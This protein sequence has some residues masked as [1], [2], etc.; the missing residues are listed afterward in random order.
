MKQELQNT[1]GYTSNRIYRF[2]IIVGMIAISFPYIYITH[3]LPGVKDSLT[4]R[5]IILLIFSFFGI[6]SYYNNIIIKHLPHLARISAFIF[7]LFHLW[8]NYHNRFSPENHYPLILTFAFMAWLLS[9]RIQAV[10]FYL[11]AL[12][13]SILVIYITDLPQNIT[14]SLSSSIVWV[15]IL[16]FIF[17]ELNLR[18]KH[19]IK[20][21]MHEKEKYHALSIQNEAAFSSKWA[22]AMGVLQEKENFIEDLRNNESLNEF[23]ISKNNLG[24]WYINVN[25]RTAYFSDRWKEILGYK[26]DE[27]PNH[28]DSYYELL[29][30]NPSCSKPAI[31]C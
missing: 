5:V 17:T 18:N 11:F 22:Q 14:L 19:R 7:M 4:L 10:L 9:S 6:G 25:D 23:I 12:L 2:A 26:P 15:C 29:D 1:E 27:I 30:P 21:I 24:V 3:F 8:L 13:S 28:I 31:N 16:G 20:Q